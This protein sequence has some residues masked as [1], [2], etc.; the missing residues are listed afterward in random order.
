VTALQTIKSRRL[1]AFEPAVLTIGSIHGGDR[2]FN[3]PAAVTLQ[4]SARTFSNDARD[5]LVRLMRETLAGI[6]SAS[7]ATFDLQFNPV[8]AVVVNDPKLVEQS[9][10]S[11][12][13]AVGATNVVEIPRR[14]GG[15]DFSYFGQVVPAFLFRLG[16]G[17]KSKAI[18]AEAHT[19]AFDIDEDCLLVGVKAMATLLAEFTDQPDVRH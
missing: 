18:T 11:L 5:T 13:R 4:G 10:A 2:P 8:T 19:P 12:R 16:S 1:D 9:L 15:E 7:G 17:N 3:T 14:M 6:T